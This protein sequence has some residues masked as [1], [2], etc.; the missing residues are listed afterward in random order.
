MKEG[1]KRGEGRGG[2]NKGR[3]DNSGKRDK[4][5]GRVTPIRAISN[6]LLI[7]SFFLKG[8]FDS[9]AYMQVENCG[10]MLFRK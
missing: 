2:E 5:Q 3:C 7:R 4:D 8:Y 6:L 1:R 9:T 10:C